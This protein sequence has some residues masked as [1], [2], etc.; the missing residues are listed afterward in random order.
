MVTILLSLVI[1]GVAN[2]SQTLIKHGQVAETR[3]DRLSAADGA[4]RDALERLRLSR[5]LCS[6]VARRRGVRVRH[7]LPGADQRCDRHGDVSADRQQG[8]RS[9]GV[10]DRDHG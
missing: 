5:S 6:T 10:G 7:D 4:L 9:P 1:V 8:R 2:Y 3:A